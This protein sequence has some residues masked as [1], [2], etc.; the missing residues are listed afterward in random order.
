VWWEVGD[1]AIRTSSFAR[2]REEF[3]GRELHFWNCRGQSD[4]L[5]GVRGPLGEV[6]KGQ[7]VG[8]RCCDTMCSIIPHLQTRLFS[9]AC[10]TCSFTAA[11][12]TLCQRICRTFERK[13]Y[14]RLPRSGF[15]FPRVSIISVIASI[16]LWLRLS[17]IR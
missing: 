11:L 15:Y 4:R 6:L 1:S 3:N 12:G 9:I 8:V 2:P 16:R 7:K 13:R 5:L 10:K 14:A 17:G